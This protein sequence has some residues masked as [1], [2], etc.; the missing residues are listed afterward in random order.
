M[1]RKKILR[2]EYCGNVKVTVEFHTDGLMRH[3]VDDRLDGLTSEVMRA[4]AAETRVPISRIS[5]K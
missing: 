3:E 5:I 2:V 4:L 1:K